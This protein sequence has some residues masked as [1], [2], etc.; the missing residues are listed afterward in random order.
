MIKKQRKI[1][2]EIELTNSGVNLSNLLNKN[3]ID[4]ELCIYTI[5]KIYPNGFEGFKN[6]L[7]NLF[8][9]KISLQ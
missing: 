7:L 8:E 5:K 9:E 4:E 6:D 2:V 1:L 3:L